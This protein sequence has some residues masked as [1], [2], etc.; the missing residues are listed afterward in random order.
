MSYCRSDEKVQER[1]TFHSNTLPIEFKRIKRLYRFYYFLILVIAIKNVMFSEDQSDVQEFFLYLVDE[2]SKEVDSLS[3][4]PQSP[5]IENTNNDDEWEEVGSKGKKLV[6]RESVIQRS[7]INQLFE[8]QL[9]KKV[10]N[11]RV[12]SFL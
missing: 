2:I 11:F 9:R 5:I 6:I 8:V 1:K 10:E 7:I 12:L 3:S 4:N